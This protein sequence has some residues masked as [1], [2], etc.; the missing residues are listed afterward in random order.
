[1]NQKQKVFVD[2]VWKFYAEHGRHDLPWRKSITPYKILVSEIMLQQTQ[3]D[4]VIPK[5]KAFMKQFPSL[6]ALAKASAKDVIAA[7]SGLGYNRR[8]LN[9]QKAAQEVRTRYNGR[10][11]NSYDTLITLPGI[12]P[13]T[14]A[15]ILAFAYNIPH[16]T[17]ETNIRT[18]FIFHFFKHTKEVHDNDLMQHVFA[19]LPTENIREW[20]WALMDYGSHLKKVHGNISRQSKHHIK[21]K[22]FKGS[23]REIRGNI[24]KLLIDKKRTSLF[25]YKNIAAE[26]TRIDTQLTALYKEQ[27]ISKQQ[28]FWSLSDH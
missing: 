8:A 22:P 2:T 25:L 5:Y 4:R 23:D 14:A 6:A 11:P 16:P 19:T 15:A 26:K 24:I 17:L 18:V 7:W 9:L 20:Y 10:L 3:V 28:Q 12:G 21:Q 1:M 27:L 13:Y